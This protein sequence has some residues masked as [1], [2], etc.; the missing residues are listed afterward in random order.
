MVD[1]YAGHALVCYRKLRRLAP[2]DARAELELFERSVLQFRLQ[3]G[4]DDTAT[5]ASAG[6]AGR[7][8]SAV[9]EPAGGG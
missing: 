2:A 1:R 3:S 6:R 8:V 7:P 9:G 5:T 4:F